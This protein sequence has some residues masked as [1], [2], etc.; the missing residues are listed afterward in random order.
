MPPR[1]RGLALASV[2]RGSLGRVRRGWPAARVREDADGVAERAGVRQAQ[3]G[4]VLAVRAGPHR[5]GDHVPQLAR[6]STLPTTTWTST[7]DG[8]S[9][10]RSTLARTGIVAP[11]TGA[12]EP[13]TVSSAHAPGPWA[14]RADPRPVRG[15]FP[16]P[17]EP[18]VAHRGHG[19]GG[20]QVVG[21]HVL[22]DHPARPAPS[23]P[24][25]RSVCRTM[26]SQPA[27]TPSGRGR[28]TAAPPGARA[29]R[30]AR[31]PPG[32]RGGRRRSTPSAVGMAQPFLPS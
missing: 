23:G 7:S 22:A 14:M 25:T 12:C 20:R 15:Q 5:R 6:S 24:A 8:A 28:R 21:V 31:R 30:R 11:I 18:A 17:G 19:G 26:R 2:R 10:A 16:G 9:P 13:S 27:G 1:R 32:R 3:V 4:Q 29:G